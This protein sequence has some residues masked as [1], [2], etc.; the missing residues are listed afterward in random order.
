M[1]AHQHDRNRNKA[2]K[3]TYK[4]AFPTMGVFAIRNQFSGRCYV[5]QSSNLTGVLNR[6]RLE[7]KWGVHRNRA[8]QED[9][10]T[11]GEEQFRFEILEQVAERKE[12][13]FDYAAER[14]RLLLLWRQR[15]LDGGAQ[16]YN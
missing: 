5:D 10:R 12:V 11:H 14:A 8:L 16:T 3:Q 2:L 13:G 15:L 9:W 4:L 6:H 1:M 7:L